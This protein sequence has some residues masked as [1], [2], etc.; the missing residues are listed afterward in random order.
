VRELQE[1]VRQALSQAYRERS[2]SGKEQDT[3]RKQQSAEQPA[4]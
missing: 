2:E 3:G 4:I 1:Q